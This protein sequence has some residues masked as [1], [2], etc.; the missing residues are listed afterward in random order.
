[1]CV[2][3]EDARYPEPPLC[4]CSSSYLAQKRV[5]TDMGGTPRSPYSKA[6]GGGEGGG[7]MEVM[8]VIIIIIM[9]I[10]HDD[11]V[12]MAAATTK[13]THFAPSFARPASRLTTSKNAM[14]LPWGVVSRS[15]S[16]WDDGI[17]TAQPIR[18]S[19]SRLRAHR[20]CQV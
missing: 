9:I 2:A 13:R 15:G 6:R 11:Y 1:M 8:L 19:A 4:S 20:H 7:Q 17:Y 3:F 16:G 18:R 10:V 12:I 5:H 14:H